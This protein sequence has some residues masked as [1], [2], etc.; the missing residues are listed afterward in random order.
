[1]S[2]ELANFITTI[3]EVERQ[4]GLDFFAQTPDSIEDNMESVQWEEMWPTNQ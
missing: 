2:S 1:S 3:D 4:T